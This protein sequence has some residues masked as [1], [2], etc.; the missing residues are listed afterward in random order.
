[1]FKFTLS[2]YAEL[3]NPNY[4]KILL[5][6]LSLAGTCTIL[7]LI[8]G[9]PFAFIIAR[10]KSR[11]RSLLLLLVIIPFW[12]ITVYKILVKKSQFK[13]KG[14]SILNKDLTKEMSHQ[15]KISIE[16]E[17]ACKE[18]EMHRQVV[19]DAITIFLSKAK[20]IIYHQ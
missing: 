8:I 9:Y 15:M 19:T 12:I 17:K 6:S 14:L 7:C 16:K 13:E 1:M 2:N 11:H 18:L 10:S 20:A 4:L 5:D 3:F